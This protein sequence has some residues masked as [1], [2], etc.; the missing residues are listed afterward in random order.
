MTLAL[1]SQGGRFFVGLGKSPRSPRFPWADRP[2]AVQL[3]KEEVL[4]NHCS[5]S[6]TVINFV[7][8]KGFEMGLWLLSDKESVVNKWKKMCLL[9]KSKL[10]ENF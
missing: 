6:R 4:K 9:E 3:L 10:K 7:F 2:D 8:G 5:C 1:A